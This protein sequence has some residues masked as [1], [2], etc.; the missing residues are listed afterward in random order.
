MEPIGRWINEG[1]TRVPLDRLVRH[2]HRQAGGFP[3]AI[4]GWRSLYQDAG[5]PPACAK[6]ARIRWKLGGSVSF[7][8]A[9]VQ[10]PVTFRLENRLRQSICEGVI[11]EKNCNCNRFAV[12]CGLR[13]GSGPEV[14]GGGRDF[15]VSDLFQMV[16]EYSAAHP[17]VESTTSPSARAAA[18]PSNQ[19]LVDF[20]ATDMPMTDAMLAASPIKLINIPT[21]LGADVPIYNVPGV[22]RRQVQPRCIGRYFPW[23][24]HKLE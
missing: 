16:C 19:R 12:V 20:G 14:H 6:M 8:Q 10:T 18:S 7:L 21:V 22:P 1:P 13:R 11:R 24:N 9:P 2:D 17:G 15:P 4:G 23:Q 5:R 3:G